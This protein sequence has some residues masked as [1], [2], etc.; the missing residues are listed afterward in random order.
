[1]T[2]SINPEKHIMSHQS[3]EE[4]LS[5]V[6]DGEA[7]E[8]ELRRVLASENAALR[9]RWARQQLVRDVLHGQTVRPHLDLAAGVAAAIE[10]EERSARGKVASPGLWQRFG[11]HV[12]AA[13]VTLAVL[14]GVRWYQG[15]EP[16]LDALASRSPAPVLQPAPA[17]VA[18][19]QEPAV[20]VSYPATD[21]QGQAPASEEAQILRAVPADAIER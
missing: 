9:A 3:L 5:A 6:M 20:L 10:A 16:A 7:D 12:V 14:A 4:S 21:S 2:G 11:R 1:M 13:S 8:L 17:G 18:V 15:G 19:P